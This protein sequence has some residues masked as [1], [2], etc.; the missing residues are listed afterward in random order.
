MIQRSSSRVRA[1]EFPDGL[2]WLNVERPLALR[3]LRGRLVILDF[4]TSCCINCHH[5][6]EEL[7]KVEERF[8]EEVVTI[9]VHCPKFHAEA[10]VHS[11]RQA[12]IRHDVGHP[13]VSDADFQVWRAYAVRAWPTIVLIDPMG[14]IIA[15]HSGEF[16][17][18]A[19][20]GLIQSL[21]A[22]YDR[23]GLL[24]RGPVP[25]W[26]ERDTLLE[27]PLCYPASVLYDGE[28]GRLFVSDTGHHRVLE[29][30]PASLALVRAW[31]DGRPG[32]RDGLP[33]EAQFHSPRGL[34]RMGGRLLVADTG[35]HKVRAI[36]LA[37]GRAETTAGTGQQA[38][39]AL[40]EATGP[41]A[42]NSPW[43]LAC[44]TGGAVFIAMSGAHQ[45]WRLEPESGH[46]SLFAGEGVE[47]L[48]DGPRLRARL[49]QPSGLSLCEGRLWIAD[50]ES[51]SLRSAPVEGEGDVRTH[52]GQ[53][54]FDFGD[55]DGDL[56]EARMQHPLGVAATGEAVYVSDTY[57]HKIRRLDLASGQ[58]VTLAGCGEAGPEDGVG[59]AACFWEP[60][61]LSLGRG[62]I[63]VA[64]TNNHAI[65][66]ISLA[67]GKTGTLEL[68]PPL[69]G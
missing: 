59:E 58:L 19:L 21:V 11:I 24:Q 37:S 48:R 13:V 25:V 36:D 44:G 43:D 8:P 33:G 23:D 42:L 29:F 66:R 2:Q 32:D 12:I 26:P 67:D 60:Q 16:E 53:G 69:P 7:R 9:G 64:D 38:R 51:S 55:R 3:Q 30:D 34:A 41:A 54:L 1:P 14:T 57:N 61:G 27:L 5:T 50:S 17:G 15:Q 4:W 56:S 39:R 6:L 35:N 62:C 28:A 10:E 68:E 46:L 20:A 22:E 63:Y 65:R 47:G 52:V 40:G 45:V 49:A 31:G 18:E